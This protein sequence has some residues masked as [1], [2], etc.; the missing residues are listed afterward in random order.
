MVRP[1]SASP[2]R[3]RSK[4]SLPE[5]RRGPLRGRAGRRGCS[6]GA[7]L[8]RPRARSLCG[9]CPSALGAVLRDRIQTQDALRDG[10]PAFHPEEGI[11]RLGSLRMHTP[12]SAYQ[13]HQEHRTGT[14]EVGKQAD[15]VYTDR[16]LLKV[17]ATEISD[18]KAEL[19]MIGGEIVHEAGSVTAASKKTHASTAAAK[20]LRATGAVCG[21][22]HSHA[23]CGH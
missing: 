22:G 5:I 14:L 4:A 7:H 21:P 12:G 9:T 10:T 20:T 3:T 16:D 11:S 6:C 13:L 1:T 2:H 15:L 18:T 23:A 19:T 17:K 8:A